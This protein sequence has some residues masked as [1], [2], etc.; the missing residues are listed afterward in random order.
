[1]ERSFW[2]KIPSDISDYSEY[3]ILY[4]KLYVRTIIILGLPIAFFFTIYNL[5]LSRYLAGA[6]VLLMFLVLCL[7]MYDVA[8]KSEPLK[9]DMFQEVLFRLFLSSFYPI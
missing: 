1:M 7:F 9:T 8:K 5:Y 2:V 3:Q 6:L 4:K